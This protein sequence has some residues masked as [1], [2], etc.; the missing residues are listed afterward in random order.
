MGEDQG[1]DYYLH[2]YWAQFPLPQLLVREEGMPYAQHVY[3]FPN[4]DTSWGDWA[5]RVARMTSYPQDL[6]ITR[7]IPAHWPDQ[8]LED[9]GA[10]S[11]S[12]TGQ[13]A[14][15]SPVALF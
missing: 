7:V 3:S 10:P 9:A 4:Y 13:G 2:I 6:I 15:F 12:T 14:K 11:R 5:Q 1:V 8:D